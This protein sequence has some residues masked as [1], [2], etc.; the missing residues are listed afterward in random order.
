MVAAPL[1]ASLVSRLRE[2]ELDLSLE[3][4]ASECLALVGPSGAGKSTVLRSIAGLHRPDRG[5][6]RLGDA[7]WFDEST[8]TDLAPERR[9]CGYLFQDYA[10][11]PHLNAWRNVAFGLSRL[12]RSQRRARAVD[13]LGRFGA[14]ELAE[15]PPR[16]LSGGERQR[17]AL[18]RALSREPGLI[19]LDEPLAALDSRTA[20]AAARELAATLAAS[21]SPAVLVTHDFAEAALLADRIAV[22]DRGRIV[23]QGAA[24]EL[25][26]RP[27]S[28][29]VADF[30]GAT[31][32][33]GSARRSGA[34]TTTIELD[35]G[36]V[37]ASSDQA[38]GEVGVAVYPWEI[39]LEPAGTPAHG[40][41]LNRL[42]AKVV[43]VTEVGNRARVGL[44]AGQPLAAEVTGESVSRLGLAPG[45]RVVASWKATATRLVAR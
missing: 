42:D 12:P 15:A 43:S 11:F 13:L 9:D 38:E 31:V 25:S 36:G 45:T 28:A 33:F 35:G 29:F 44:L 26:A 40:S 1:D 27:G 32:L 10:L 39:T 23:Q 16:R 8:G 34:G 6:V 4:G 14:A 30:T 21:D 5:R 3:V 37:L 17:V 2:Y 24:A 41:A 18:A 20:A 22:V 19:L 7:V